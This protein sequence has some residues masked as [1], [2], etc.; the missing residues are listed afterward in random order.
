MNTLR[1]DI[2]GEIEPTENVS[3][4]SDKLPEEGPFGTERLLRQAQGCLIRRKPAS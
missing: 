4:L 3:M 1:S 2:P